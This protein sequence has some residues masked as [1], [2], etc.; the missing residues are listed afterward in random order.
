MKPQSSNEVAEGLKII[1]S[2]SCIFAVLVGGTS[3]FKGGL[4]AEGGVT[5]DLRRLNSVRLLEGGKNDSP[6]VEVGGGTTW[7]RLYEFLDKRNLSS[8]GTRNSMTG[9]VGSILGGVSPE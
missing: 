8:A 1:V 5:I 7:A 2:H 3:P 6:A 9:V 4:N